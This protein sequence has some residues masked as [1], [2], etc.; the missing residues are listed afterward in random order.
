[1]NERERQNKMTAKATKHY[2]KVLL[3]NFGLQPWKGLI[4]DVKLN[5]F[6]AQKH[7]EAKLANEAFRAWRLSSAQMKRH[8]ENGILRRYFDS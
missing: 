8:R 6:I 4:A 1:M 2:S 7:Y 5:N 3:S